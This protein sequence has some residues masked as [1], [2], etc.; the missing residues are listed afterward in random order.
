MLRRCA[1]G[2]E[3]QTFGGIMKKKLI[4]VDIVLVIL[5]VICVG[6][7]IALGVANPVMLLIAAAVLAVLFV[8]L[9][10]NIKRLRRAIAHLLH[11]SGY[12]DSATQHSLT[13]FKVPVLVLS[14]KSIVWDNEAFSSGVLTDREYYLE[15]VYKA[16]PGFDPEK[17]VRPSGQWLEAE[18]RSF[19]VFGSG[20]M[21]GDGLFVAYFINDTQ[22]KTEA[23]EY[24]ASR[25]SVL[26]ITVDTYEEVLKD[27]KDS[28]RAALTGEIDR[29]FEKFIDGTSGF[30]LRLSSSRY[31][32]VMEE[33]H[34]AKIIEGRF[35]ILDRMRE[36]SNDNG[37]VTL[38]IGVGRGGASFSECEKMAR[39]A[40]DMALGRGGDQ[41]AVRTPDGSFE[42]YGGVSRSVEKRTKVKSRIIASALSDIIRQSDSVLIMGHKMS[43]L[44]AIGAAIGVLR[45]CMIMEN[46]PRSWWT[47][48]TPL[49]AA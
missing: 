14:G 17:V 9:L 12:E 36:I 6:L 34:I 49:R 16:L 4:T 45:F 11:G 15:S 33:R 37:V 20:T 2:K 23:M 40:L 24:R 39:T 10:L 43:D 25:P 44:D 1:G 27:L 7:T 5:S 31:L 22:L 47:K 13:N 8:V 29:V 19:T 26:Y 35:A 21:R 18:G 3:G 41:A 30:L 42:F 32:A 28:E 48:N 46:P 38:S